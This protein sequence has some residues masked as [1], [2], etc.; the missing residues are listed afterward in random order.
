MERAGLR[1]RERRRS[2]IMRSE[3]RKKGREKD[4]QAT[5]TWEV[6][7]RRGRGGESQVEKIRT[8]QEQD[9]EMERGKE[10]LLTAPGGEREVCIRIRSRRVFENIEVCEYVYACA[11]VVKEK[12]AK[13]N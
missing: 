9:H 13:K 8:H 12:N 3:A 6:L 4:P 2:M 7:W 1:T 10:W 11:H 5:R